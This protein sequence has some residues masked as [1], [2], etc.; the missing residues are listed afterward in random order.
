MHELSQF[1]RPESPPF[2]AL[3]YRRVAGFPARRGG[4]P[5]ALRREGRE[6]RWCEEHVTVP[7]G[8]ATLHV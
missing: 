1:F 3:V 2:G 5:A 4:N 7:R 8:G 6:G